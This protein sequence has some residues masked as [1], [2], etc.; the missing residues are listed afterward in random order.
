MPSTYSIVFWCADTSH[1]SSFAGAHLLRA[2]LSTANRGRVGNEIPIVVG[3]ASSRRLPIW[4]REVAARG[5]LQPRR[6]VVTKKE[7]FDYLL[8]FGSGQHVEAG[9]LANHAGDA[10]V[11][12]A[13]ELVEHLDKLSPNTM[14]KDDIIALLNRLSRSPRHVDVRCDHI[15]DLR[16]V[17]ALCQRMVLSLN[18]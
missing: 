16:D 14:P 7:R 8:T 3:V 12:A 4:S 1:L 13:P 5:L 10:R 11:I 6:P 18:R 9:K 17:A 2:G 15:N